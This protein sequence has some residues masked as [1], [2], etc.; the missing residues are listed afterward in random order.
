MCCIAQ[1]SVKDI[2][3][4][5]TDF[6]TRTDSLLVLVLLMAR[7]KAIS[8]KRYTGNKIIRVVG[9]IRYRVVV[10]I[11]RDNGGVLDIPC[12]ERFKKA[13]NAHRFCTNRAN[14][15][16]YSQF[17]AWA[18]VQPFMSFTCGHCDL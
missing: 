1:I 13:A 8:R 7:T 2:L 10:H 3:S 11:Q 18:S 16:L 12:A 4:S 9:V 6:K 5:D 14:Q 17:P 15:L